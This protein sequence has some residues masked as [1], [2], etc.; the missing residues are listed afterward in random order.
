[1]KGDVKVSAFPAFTGPSAEDWRG[2]SPFISVIR[3]LGL[4]TDPR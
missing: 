2:L 4:Y 1:M 3:G